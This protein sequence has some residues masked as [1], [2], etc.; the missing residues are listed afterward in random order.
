MLTED[1]LKILKYISEIESKTLAENER[2][3]WMDPYRLES[4]EKQNLLMWMPII[5]P[6]YEGYE[7]G[8]YGWRISPEGE[9]SIKQHLQDVAD[10]ARKIAEQEAEKQRVSVDRRKDRIHSAVILIIGWILGN[11]TPVDVLDWFIE[12]V[13]KMMEFLH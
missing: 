9:D 1:N 11:I 3:F 8:L 10:Q 12:A 7:H 6:G 2:P 5:P 4:L 13:A